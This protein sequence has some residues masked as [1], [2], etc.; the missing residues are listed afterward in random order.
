MYE[1]LTKYL[2][3]FPENNFGEWISR[4]GYFSFVDYS[5]MVKDLRKDI[6]NFVDENPDLR[7]YST[8]L[9]KHG[10]VSM[11]DADVST[12][13]GKTILALL[14]AIDRE[15]H[16]C[17]GALLRYLEDGYVEK[18]LRRLKEIDSESQKSHSLD[19]S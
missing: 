16:F 4:P 1:S 18:W 7:N 10:I 15:N 8:I 6:Y 13:D 2:D 9:N 3:S 14:V 5:P 12:L 17:E 19:L 11:T